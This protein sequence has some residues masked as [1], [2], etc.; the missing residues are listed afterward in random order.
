[1]LEDVSV[2]AQGRCICSEYVARDKSNKL[3]S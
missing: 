2:H 3:S 1:L